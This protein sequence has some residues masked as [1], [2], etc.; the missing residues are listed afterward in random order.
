MN[1][2]NILIRK[3]LEGDEAGIVSLLD[4]TFNGWP[5]VDTELSPIEYW[6]WKYLE[7]PLPSEISVGVDGTKI[8]SCHHTNTLKIQLID[9]EIPGATALDFAVHPDYRGMGLS[10]RTSRCT[11]KNQEHLGIHFR[12]FITRNPL[13]I[14]SYQDSSTPKN[15][16]PFFPKTLVNMTRIRDIDLQL[17]TMPEKYGSLKGIGVKGL[18]KWNQ[19]TTRKGT[20]NKDLQISLEDRFTG[21]TPF[22]EKISDEYRFMVKRS[23]EYLNWKYAY[24]KLGDYRISIISEGE[25]M[26]GYSV[27]RINRYNPHYPVG[28]IVD[29]LTLKDRTDALNNLLFNATTYFDENNINIVNSQIIKGHYSQK[30]LE[31]HGF[32]DSRIKIQMYYNLGAPIEMA[33]LSDTHPDLLFISWGDHDVLPVG[34]R[35]F[36]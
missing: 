34:K 12:Y 32:L 30:L 31:N 14:K 36:D 17:D 35:K 11:E 13:L 19:L 7:T 15:R 1:M 5:H 23:E 3:Y 22:L 2:S 25:N 28:Y 6:R 10:S 9:K 29:M 26:L 24:P 33:T 4:S 27:L 21:C 20:I 18:Q 16:R 8:V